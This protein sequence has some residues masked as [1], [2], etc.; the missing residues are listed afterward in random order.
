MS[1]F[2]RPLNLSEKEVLLNTSLDQKAISKQKVPFYLYGLPLGAFLS[3]FWIS[4]TYPNNLGLLFL[5]ILVTFVAL[6]YAINRTTTI[7]SNIKDAKANIAEINQILQEDNIQLKRIEFTKGIKLSV[8]D[9]YIFYCM[10]TTNNEVFIIEYFMP[11]EEPM[12]YS[13][14]EFYQNE[15]IQSYLGDASKTYENLPI[16]QKLYSHYHRLPESLELEDQK[17][18]PKPL[19]DFLKDYEEAVKIIEIKEKE[20]EERWEKMTTEEV[21]EDVRKTMVDT[22]NMLMNAGK[23]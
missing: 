17:I 21:L 18:I 14:I 5:G 15:Q 7:Y 1:L 9:S 4:F 22:A 3:I 11:D 8:K 2:Y 19:D 16:L 13:K 10:E 6:I 20:K 12:P 23:K